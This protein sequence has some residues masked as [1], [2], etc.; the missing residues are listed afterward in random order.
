MLLDKFINIPIISSRISYYESKGYDI[1]KYKDNWGR[2]KVKKN[3]EIKVKVK[4][5]PKNSKIKV[6]WKCNN[7]GIEKMINYNCLS[8]VCQKCN[9]KLRF[10]ENHPA[11][12]GGRPKC[13]DCGKVLQHSKS[14]RCQHC[15]IETLKGTYEDCNR[16][17]FPGSRKW[18]RLVKNRD[19]NECQCCGSKDKI[20]VHHI[21]N[22]ADNK[23][24]RLDIN[25]GIVLCEDCHIDFH[26]IYGKSFNNRQQLNEFLSEKETD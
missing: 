25:N 18:L 26:R 15:Y 8:K 7:C 19:N 11:W 5:L 24:K 17:S 22:F 21:K 2:M 1:P 9:H 4:D 23:E 6:R 3:T 12:K 13:V 16:R 14:K 10:G 20:R